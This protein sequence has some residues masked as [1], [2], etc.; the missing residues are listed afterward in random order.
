MILEKVITVHRMRGLDRGLVRRIIHAFEEP[1]IQ[2]PDRCLSSVARANLAKYSLH[3]GL[4]GR[5]GNT[6]KSCNMLVRVSSDNPLKYYDLSRRQLLE[7]VRI[8][9]STRRDVLD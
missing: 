1:M 3:V 5:L 8:V 9:L 6:E 4:Y 2:C 7:R